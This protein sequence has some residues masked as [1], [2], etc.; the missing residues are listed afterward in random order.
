M[1]HKPYPERYDHHGHK[2]MNGNEN[3]RD[4]VIGDLHGC[5]EELM[6]CLEHV[7]FDKTKD[8]L[9]AL[10]DLN[11]RGEK[12]LECLKLLKEEW[13][14][15]VLGNHEQMMM[16]SVIYGERINYWI[17]CGGDWYGNLFDDD[18][19]EVKNLIDTIVSQLP[20]SITIE[21]PNRKVGLLHANPP[22]NWKDLQTGKA[23]YAD[24]V[25]GRQKIQACDKEPIQDI[26]TVFVGHDTHDNV[27]KLGNVFYLDTGAVYN[28]FGPLTMIGLSNS[29]S[30]RIV[31]PDK[32]D[33]N[34]TS[35]LLNDFSDF[36]EDHDSWNQWFD[37]IPSNSGFLTDRDKS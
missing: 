19:K 21:M 1:A 8:R 24:T 22:C 29:G 23:D 15:S 4:F 5:F 25:W 10:G 30:D 11:D 32:G 35:N 7:S 17:K 6:Q 31:S 28:Y 12:S 27:R 33:R 37:R 3:G 20:H 26:D 16:D 9:F 13:F 18:Q 14:F 36:E 34:K 2:V